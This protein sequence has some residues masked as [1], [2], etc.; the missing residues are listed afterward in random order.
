MLNVQPKFQNFLEFL[1]MFAHS[2]TY[3]KQWVFTPDATESDIQQGKYPAGYYNIDVVRYKS[4][5][6]EYDSAVF[7]IMIYVYDTGHQ[8]NIRSFRSVKVFSEMIISIGDYFPVKENKEIFS[9]MT[10]DDFD[11]NQLIPVIKHEF[12]RWNDYIN[13]PEFLENFI[14][15]ENS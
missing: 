2:T 10:N 3:D 14:P 7:R 15:E 1:A 9:Q 8:V 6:Y 12:H 5:V 11:F 4:E 13:H